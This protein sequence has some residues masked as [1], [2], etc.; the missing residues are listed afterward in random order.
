MK[1]NILE[2]K[3]K[4]WHMLWGV[5]FF[6]L[7]LFTEEIIYK[8]ALLMLLIIGVIVLILR[9]KK[10]KVGIV[11][12]L[13]EKL[14]RKGEGIEASFYYVLSIFVS[15]LFFEQRIVAL[16]ALALGVCDGLATIVGIHGK[17]KLYKNKTVEGTSAFFISCFLIIYL[18]GYYKLVALICSAI[19]ALVEL[20]TDVNDNLIIPPIFSL[21]LKI[22]G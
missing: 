21:I 4:V 22:I 3:R 7:I 12:Y 20:L 1:L 8:S 17:N 6:F 18:A 2:I 15:S 10:I 9:Q 11:E 16:S 5:A 13:I 14:G 19:L